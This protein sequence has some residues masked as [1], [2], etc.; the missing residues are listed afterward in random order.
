M[1]PYISVIEYEKYAISIFNSILIARLYFFQ[2]KVIKPQAGSTQNPFPL[3]TSQ[4]IV[5]KDVNIRSF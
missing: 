5:P 2:L 3:E 4:N 1:I